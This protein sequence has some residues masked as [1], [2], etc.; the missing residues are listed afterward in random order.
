[1]NDKDKTLFTA[2]LQ[3]VAT[4]FHHDIPLSGTLDKLWTLRLLHYMKMNF[5]FA[6]RT[7]QVRKLTLHCYSPWLTKKL[8]K[9][10]YIL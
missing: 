1:M 7:G 9:V 10:G 3:G 5:A 4:G 6:K 2:L 8:L